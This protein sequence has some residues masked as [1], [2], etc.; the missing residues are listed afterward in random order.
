MNVSVYPGEKFNVSLVAVGQFHNPVPATI[1]AYIDNSS[2]T[3]FH[4]T[5]KGSCT[6]H[7]FYVRGN[8]SPKYDVLNFI[9]SSGTGY[10]AGSHLRWVNISY[11]HCP[12]GTQDK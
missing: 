11:K 7:T 12:L 6:N 8:H 10:T 9:V 3:L 1:R 5:I 4:I 2:K